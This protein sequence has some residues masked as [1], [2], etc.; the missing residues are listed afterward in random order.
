MSRWAPSARFSSL[1]RGTRT[2]RSAVTP[3]VRSCTDIH[4]RRESN[5]LPVARGPRVAPRELRVHTGAAAVDSIR[6]RR[7]TQPTDGETWGRENGPVPRGRTDLRGAGGLDR[8]PI[9]GRRPEPPCR[10]S[11]RR[12]GAHE[13]GAIGSALPIRAAT[14]ALGTGDGTHQRSGF[15]HHAIS[16]QFPRWEVTWQILNRRCIKITAGMVHY[17]SPARRPHRIGQFEGTGTPGRSRSTGSGSPTGTGS[18][19]TN[20]SPDGRCRGFEYAN[21]PTACDSSSGD[22]Q[23]PSLPAMPSL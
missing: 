22:A 2:V 5:A 4:S 12:S 23:G 16:P 14:G 8:S 1:S 20:A 6:G 19:R 7:W 3:T 18:T 15:G 11:R 10:G 21:V 17:H 9:R 13:V